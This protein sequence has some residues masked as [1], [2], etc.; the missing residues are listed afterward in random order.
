MFK[1]KIYFENQVKT[2]KVF[3]LP[4][5]FMSEFSSMTFF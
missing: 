3:T 1:D 5:N 4:K 2:K